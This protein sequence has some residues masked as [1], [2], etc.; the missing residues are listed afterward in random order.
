MN[1]TQPILWEEMGA[2]MPPYAPHPNAYDPET[3]SFKP[4]KA[5]MGPP[6]LLGYARQP[7]WFERFWLELTLTYY[8]HPTKVARAYGFILTVEDGYEE[9][10]HPYTPCWLDYLAVY[11]MREVYKRGYK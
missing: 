3:D 1:Y 11:Y 5:G 6:S 4:L 8:R 9:I 2:N 10:G 7:S